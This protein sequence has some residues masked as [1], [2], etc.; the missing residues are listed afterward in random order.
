MGFTLISQIG[1]GVATIAI[2][3]LSLPSIKA[4]NKERFTIA[5]SLT[6]VPILVLIYAMFFKAD[7][8]YLLYGSFICIIISFPIGLTIMNYHKK[9]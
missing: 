7:N 8:I 2:L 6:I 4:V 9:S 5:M 1:S 3:I